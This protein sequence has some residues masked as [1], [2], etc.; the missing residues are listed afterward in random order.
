MVDTGLK[1]VENG[2][3]PRLIEAG[4]GHR[5]WLTLVNSGWQRKIHI[6]KPP[7]NY[8]H[9]YE[10]HHDGW[11][12]LQ[13][14]SMLNDPLDLPMLVAERLL[15]Y[16]QLVILCHDYT[17]GED[18]EPKKVTSSAGRKNRDP[19]FQIQTITSLRHAYYHSWKAPTPVEIWFPPSFH[20]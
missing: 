1:M 13:V 7:T 3:E 17:L 6:N 10:A 9:L 4:H 2:Y 8:Q 19:I 5:P 20:P 15:H 16:N 11:E 12:N 18:T 14:V